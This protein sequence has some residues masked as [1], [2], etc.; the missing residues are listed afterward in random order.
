MEGDINFI[1]KKID[2]VVYMELEYIIC[3]LKYEQFVER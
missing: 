2:R 3:V 1:F